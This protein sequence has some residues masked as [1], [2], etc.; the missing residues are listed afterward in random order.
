MI[1]NY[2]I[3]KKQ[4]ALLES[5]VFQLSSIDFYSVIQSSRR[6]KKFLEGFGKSYCY[7]FNL[8]QLIKVCCVTEMI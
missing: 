7:K 2:R 1:R 4:L 3:D 5:N 6:F 8:V